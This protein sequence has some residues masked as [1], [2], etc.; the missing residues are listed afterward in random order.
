VKKERLFFGFM[1]TVFW[2]SFAAFV[3]ITLDLSITHKTANQ[4]Y[5]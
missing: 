3:S 1:G 4:I 2:G 5:N